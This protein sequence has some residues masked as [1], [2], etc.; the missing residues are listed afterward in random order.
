MANHCPTSHCDKHYL[1]IKIYDG[2]KSHCNK[3]CIGMKINHG[4]QWSN[5]TL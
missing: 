4:Q 5:I 1:N 2:P 3:G